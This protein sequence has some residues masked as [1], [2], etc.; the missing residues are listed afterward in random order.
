MKHIT[1][2]RQDDRGFYVDLDDRTSA[3]SVN[4]RTRDVLLDEGEGDDRYHGAVLFG[5]DNP[6]FIAKPSTT[7]VDV[8][9]DFGTDR[10]RH[11]VGQSGAE[12]TLE[13]V[14]RVNESLGGVGVP[15]EISMDRVPLTDIAVESKL[16]FANVYERLGRILNELSNSYRSCE[17]M[18]EP[19]ASA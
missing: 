8:Y 1:S 19:L 14:C 10:D 2:L 13:W 4:R 11:F 9:L 17:K 16:S 12:Q 7:G 6:R 15:F 3:I 18:K 5:A